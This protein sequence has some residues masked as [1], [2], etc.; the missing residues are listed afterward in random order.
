M[1]TISSIKF[2]L[3]T[4]AFTWTLFSIVI[5][6]GQSNQDFPAMLLYILGG[7]APSLVA[8][9]FVW[10]TF[11]K[12]QRDDFWSRVINPRRIKPVW[13]V[14]SLVVIPAVMGLAIWLNTRLFNELPGMEILNNLKVQPAEIPVFIIMM[15]IGGPLAEELGWRGFLLDAFQ[16]KWSP[17]ISTIILFLIWWIWHLP[18]FFIPGTSHYNWGL[19]T[20]MFWLFAMNVFLLTILMTLAFNANQRS[21]L[22][23]ILIHFSYNVTLSLLVPYTTQTFAFITTFLALLVIGI[24]FVQKFVLTQHKAGKQI[25]K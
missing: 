15:L 25:S 2:I 6:S 4:F 12:E 24:I 19:F 18:L 7:C 8:I 10:R 23:A 13:W 5:F 22:I 21:V 17:A 11:N 16:K 1:K 14:V 9:F 20:N 3:A